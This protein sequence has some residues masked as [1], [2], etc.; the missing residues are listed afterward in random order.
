EVLPAISPLAKLPNNIIP[1]D[2]S[3]MLVLRDYSENVKRM[4]ELIKK[5]DVDTPQEYEP[6]VIPIKYA[7]ASDIQQVLASLTPSGAGPTVGTQA[8]G[9]GGRPVTPGGGAGR[10]GGVG[11]VGGVGGIGGQINPLTGQPSYQPGV[12]GAGLAG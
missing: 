5:V 11:G 1:I 3:M 6:V 8:G 9:A 12:T 4:L 10:L 2:S 7:L